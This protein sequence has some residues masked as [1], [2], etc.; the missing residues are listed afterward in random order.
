MNLAIFDID[1]T[2]LDNTATEDAC[3]V[4]ALHTGLG[5]DNIDQDWSRYQ[6]VTDQG[7]A[8]EAY[9]RATRSQPSPAALARTVEH[10]VAGLSE[11]CRQAPIQSV[12]GAAQ[13]LADLPRLGWMPVLATGAWRRAALFKLRSAG[14]RAAHLVLAT[15]EDGPA[16]V[17]VFRTALERACYRVDGH[18]SAS[19]FDRVVLIGDGVWDIAVAR[20]LGVPFVGRGVGS[21]AARL[22]DAGAKTVIHDY[23][24]TSAVLHALEAAAPS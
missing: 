11:A 24:D 15:S 4:H 3:F 14:L 23:S 18:T 10:F 21:G 17:A 8:C 5:L 19:S 16:R 6:H 12:R 2:L 7:I 9:E 20:E 13:L 22:R 1:G